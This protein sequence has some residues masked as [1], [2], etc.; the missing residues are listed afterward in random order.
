M[1]SIKLIDS[2]INNKKEQIKK[3]LNTKNVKR[4]EN[5]NTNLDTKVKKLIKK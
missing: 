2:L 5:T 3:D 1:Y 4:E